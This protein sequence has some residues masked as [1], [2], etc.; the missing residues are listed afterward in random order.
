MKKRKKLA[1]SLAMIMVLNLIP[2]NAFAKDVTY[3]DNDSVATQT[4]AIELDVQ[5]SSDLTQDDTQE[6]SSE[7]ILN[8]AENPITEEIITEV[9]DSAESINMPAFSDSK[10]VDGV[11]VSVSASEG[12]FPEGASLYVVS[13]S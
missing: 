1:I 9:E 12:V 10:T 5:E 4:D 6:Y 13:A 7:E 3:S 2:F 8:E 11:T